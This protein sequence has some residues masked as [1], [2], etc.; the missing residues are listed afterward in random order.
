[1]KLYLMPLMIKKV[2]LLVYQKIMMKKFLTFLLIFSFFIRKLGKLTENM[3]KKI[4]KVSVG[5]LQI[6][7]MKN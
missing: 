7:L 5:F 1:M 3:K 2:A 6:T 4:V